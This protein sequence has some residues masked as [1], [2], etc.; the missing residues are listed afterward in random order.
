MKRFPAFPEPLTHL[1]CKW[2]TAH[3]IGRTERSTRRQET[4]SAGWTEPERK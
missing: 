1:I 4:G 3:D 2:R